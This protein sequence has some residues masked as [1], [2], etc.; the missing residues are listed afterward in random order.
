MPRRDHLPDDLYLHLVATDRRDHALLLAALDECEPRLHA[1]H[2]A[3]A[4]VT[5]EATKAYAKAAILRERKEMLQD[6]MVRVATELLNLH[7]L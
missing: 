3:Y 5:A 1:L 4:V 7:R 6:E 2:E